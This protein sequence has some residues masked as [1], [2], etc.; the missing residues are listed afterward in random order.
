MSSRGG[1]YGPD[2]PAASLE[3]QESYLRGVFAFFGVTAIRV[4]QAEGVKVSPDQRERAIAA[5]RAEIGALS[6]AA[7]PRCMITGGLPLLKTTRINYGSFDD[8]CSSHVFHLP[9]WRPLDAHESARR[10]SPRCAG[11][12]TSRHSSPAWGVRSPKLC[13]SSPHTGKRMISP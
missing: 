1:F 12:L 10:Q 11:S 6:T 4:V 13:S 8:A 2:S 5:A 3:H 7:G 9:R